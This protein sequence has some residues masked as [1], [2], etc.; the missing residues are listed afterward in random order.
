MLAQ[1][2]PYSLEDIEKSDPGITA[3]FD[4]D[5]KLSESYARI[6]VMG[7]WTCSNR[8]VYLRRF[9]TGERIAYEAALNNL[10]IVSASTASWDQIL[11]FRRDSDASRKYRDLRLW[12][13]AGLSSQSI[14]QAT[15]IIGQ[16]IEDYR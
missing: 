12:L 11:E 2:Y 13:R 16:K 7:E 6:G 8:G 10:P 3:E 4:L 9:E 1:F 5:R 15:E 14:E